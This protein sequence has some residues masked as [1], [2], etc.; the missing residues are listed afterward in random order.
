ML[1]RPVV[2][3][4]LLLAVVG[5]IDLVVLPSWWVVRDRSV[6]AAGPVPRTSYMRHA[7]PLGHPVSWVWTPIDSIAPVLAC[8]VV[9]AE[10]EQFFR[11]RALSRE[12]LKHQMNAVLRAE[13]S[14]GYSGI[15][16]QLARNLYLTPSRTPRRKAREYV[17]TVALHEALS[18]QRELELHLNVAEWGKGRWGVAAASQAYL[19][20]LPSDLPPSRAI[21]LAS[22][23]PAPRREL[24]YAVGARATARQEAIATKLWRA[25]MLSDAAYGATL[26]RLRL[27]R[28]FARAGGSMSDAFAAVDSVMGR[29]RSPDGLEPQALA[30]TCDTSRRP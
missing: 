15:G 5:I 12:Q 27:W 24:A 26:D 30:S 7:D 10:D 28:S 17:L 29:E 25:S 13:F 6:L 20:V 3:I 23:L 2:S 8:A 4:A 16:Q 19:G 14:V 22:M 9:L 11:S 18:K 21:V 1:R